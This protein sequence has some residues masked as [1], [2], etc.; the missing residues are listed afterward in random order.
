VPSASVQVVVYYWDDG[1]QVKAR[2]WLGFALVALIGTL[3]LAA[4]P[5]LNPTKPRGCVG[6]QG[7]CD[8]ALAPNYRLIVIALVIGGA[9][10][11]IAL[12][13]AF[14]YRRS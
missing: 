11:L 5:F 3:W 9:V 10:T 14:R 13:A 12:I 2:L 1:G 4:I 8:P 6:V 7:P